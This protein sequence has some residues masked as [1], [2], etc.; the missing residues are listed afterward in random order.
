MYNEIKNNPDFDVL[1][2]NA[3]ET[4][5]V[6][7]NTLI[8]N[9]YDNVIVNKHENID[10]FIPVHFEVKI[11]NDTIAFIYQ[12]IACYSYN[13][14]TINENKVKIATID[15]MLSLLLAFIYA[16]RPYY[17]KNR[18]LCMAD[19]LFK[20]Q[21]KNRLSQKGPLKRF[22][23]KCYGTQ[24]TKESIRAEKNEK[25]KELKDNRNSEEYEL[26]F[27]SYQPEI[28]MKKPKKLK[29]TVKKRTKKNKTTKNKIEKLLKPLLN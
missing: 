18:I 13:L 15:T 5:N 8:A 4:A 9:N 28:D 6:L 16:N 3:E 25:Y 2:E 11:N 10:E 20:I 7:K 23:I 12:T 27:L 26:W 17:D 14:L 22:N 29:L 19:F 1:S 21:Q 24:A